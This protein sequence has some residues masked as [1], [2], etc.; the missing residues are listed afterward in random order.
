MKTSQSGIQL[1]KH[2]ESFRTVRYLCDG[3]KWT[4][5]WG[6][7][8][9]VTEDTGPITMLDGDI[10]LSIDLKEFEDAVNA[11]VKVPLLQGEFDALVSFAFNVGQDIDE[12]D[13]AEG[14]G[15]STLLKKLNAGDKKGAA[16]EITKWN[17]VTK[18][19]K[20]VVSNG[21]TH[22]R[23]AEWALF[24]GNKVTL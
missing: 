16:A 2:F 20:K 23:N 12:D 15:D 19:G 1:I 3:G 8:K 5:G 17:K 22:R 4:I 13:I 6:H 9:G 14:L 10:L 24:L 21:L 11:L 7:T 18:N